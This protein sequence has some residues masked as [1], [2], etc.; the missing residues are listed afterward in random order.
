MA[1]GSKGS[2]DQTAGNGSNGGTS[3]LDAVNAA[4]A[5]ADAARTEAVGTLTARQTALEAELEVIQGQLATLNGSTPA[6]RSGR[7]RGSGRR[8]GSGTRA[9][10]D[11]SLDVA[12]ARVLKSGGNMSPAQIASAVT[13]SGYKSNSP[14]FTSM[15]S[16]ALGRLLALRIS[17]S[18]IVAKVSHGVWQAGPG[19]EAYLADPD[20]AVEA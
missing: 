17:R 19:L 9:S 5:T 13:K 4:Q 15:C 14:N 2:Q 16:Q 6:R 12:I 11:V 20:K 10:N 8:R 18:A 3:V 1:K 7:P